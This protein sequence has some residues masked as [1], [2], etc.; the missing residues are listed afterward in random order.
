MS[1]APPLT[2]TLPECLEA[3]ATRLTEANRITGAALACA[4]A[5]AEDEAVRPV[6]GIEQRTYEAD[7][8][9]SAVTLVHRI[10]R[11]RDG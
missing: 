6:L 3:I 2:L 10:R 5:G 7:R 1:P 8:L 11:E 9:I 4:R